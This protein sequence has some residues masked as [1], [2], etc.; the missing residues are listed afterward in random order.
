MRRFVVIGQTATASPEF[1][2][3]DVPGS[4][5]RLDVLLRC[6]RAA[7]LVSHGVRRD[8]AIYLVLEG[9]PRAPRT[10]RIDGATAEYLRQDERS[11]AGTLKKMLAYV[12]DKN[13]FDAGVRGIAIAR[14]GLDVVL[15]DCGAFTPYVLDEGGAD[16][17]SAKLDADNPVFFIG[18]HLGFSAA[19]R[20]RIDALGAT[21]LS[22]GPISVHADD[23]IA[24]L[25][26]ELDR[27]R[28]KA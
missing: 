10:V 28:V 15:A 13:A 3:D 18:D 27:G 16:V 23:A 19:T 7:L 24:I 20:A 9:G 26:N 22:V 11:L 5:G 4:S 2:L 6:V 14:G 8:A 25:S 1:V 12:E 21:S 17:R